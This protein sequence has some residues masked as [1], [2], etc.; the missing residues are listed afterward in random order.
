MPAYA[1]II[2]AGIALLLA[3]VAFFYWR[4]STTPSIAMF[5]AIEAAILK[6]Q[7]I[8][9]TNILP[10]QPS[11]GAAGFNPDAMLRQTETLEGVIRFVYT[12]EHHENGL[13]HIVSSQLLRHKSLKYQIQCMLVAMLV[14]NRQLGDADI[15]QEE[16]AFDISQ[17]ELGTH[18][19][20]MFLSQEQ[21]DKFV[22]TINRPQ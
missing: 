6:L 17:S 4:N 7:Q 16:V 14:L 15:K 11:G 18:Y 20:S 2:V 10:A 22:A 5:R 3:V 1:Y 12:I 21:H 19:A 8:A 13:L 9:V